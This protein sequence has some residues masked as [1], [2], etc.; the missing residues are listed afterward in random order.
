M[1]KY[2]YSLTAVCMDSVIGNNA[3]ISP[4][5]GFSSVTYPSICACI[6][7]AKDRNHYNPNI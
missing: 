1:V 3:S 6:D 5:E 7:I 2:S 4:R